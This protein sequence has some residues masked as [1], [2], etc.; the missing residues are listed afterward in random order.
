MTSPQAGFST[1]H[2]LGTAGAALALAIGVSAC[3]VASPT[4]TTHVYAPA[5]GVRFEA[6][7]L[8]IADLLVVSEG[9]G[10]PGVISGY[11]I[12]NGAE[13][14]TVELAMSVD[15]SPQPVTPSL[16]VEPGSA[17]RLDGASGADAGEGGGGEPMTI[18]QVTPRAGQTLVLRVST[19]ADEVA[20]TTVPVLLPD[21]PYDIYAEVLDAAR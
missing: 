1:R 15:G 17:V 20:S 11:A 16:Q 2:R 7:S 18:P 19:S 13:P 21:P 8:E 4:Q 6:G 10:A 5:D 14:L 3:Q 12:N 9:A